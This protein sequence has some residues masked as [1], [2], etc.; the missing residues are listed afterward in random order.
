MVWLG[1]P[2][3]PIWTSHD[4]SNCW[5]VFSTS[6][7]LDG[8]LT[9]VTR[10]TSFAMTPEGCE[11]Q[12][13]RANAPSCLETQ[14]HACRFQTWTGH[15]DQMCRVK[16]CVSSC[17]HPKV[18]PSNRIGSLWWRCAGLNML[19][20][21]AVSG[22]ISWLQQ[23]AASTAPSRCFSQGAAQ[24]KAK[25]VNQKSRWA[26]CGASLDQPAVSPGKRNYAKFDVWIMTTKGTIG[27]VTVANKGCVWVSLQNSLEHGS[28]NKPQR[29]RHG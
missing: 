7:V 9:H 14:R 24:K 20:L 1:V 4:Q 6:L 22:A 25:K 16:H 21:W 3:S 17:S 26:K 12:G 19:T 27:G 29:F 2:C 10:A 5:D 13:L 18:E 28:N 23:V 8:L 11:D 15:V